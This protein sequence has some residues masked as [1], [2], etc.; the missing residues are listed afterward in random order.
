MLGESPHSKDALL[1]ESEGLVMSGSPG[2]SIGSWLLEPVETVV[3][4]LHGLSSHLVVPVVDL[5][6]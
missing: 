3:V 1:V 5:E 2:E 4:V 6:G